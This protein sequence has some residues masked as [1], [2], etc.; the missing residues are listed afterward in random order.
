MRWLYGLLT[1]GLCISIFS[2]T[3]GYWLVSHP[4]TTQTPSPIS[5]IVSTAPP[6]P[7]VAVVPHHNLVLDQRQALLKQLSTGSQ[8]ETIILVS[9]NHFAVGSDDVIVADKSW[10]IQQGTGSLEP[11]TDLAFLLE[12]EG[13]ASVDNLAFDTEHGIKNLLPEIAEFFPHSKL[14]PV[15]FKESVS[16]ETIQLLLTSLDS[17]CHTCG[18]IASVDMSHYQ[19]AQL[20]EIHD[21]KTLR[22]LT[23]LDEEEIWEAE[24]DSNASLAFLVGWAKKQQVNRFT[25]VD[26]T[27]SGLLA[28]NLDTETTTHIF[29][30]YDAGD[31][32]PAGNVLTFTFGGDGMFG[33][34]IGYQFQDNFSELFS[35]LGN[36]TFWGTDISWINLEGPISDQ[37]I[38][39]DR[40]RED[41]VFNFSKQTI[42][43]L[44]YLQLT[45]LGL[46]NNHT[47]NQGERGLATTRAELIEAGFDVHGHPSHVSAESVVRYTQDN[48]HVSLLAVNAL[49]STDG[50]EDL[51]QQ[52][53]QAGSVVVVLPHWGTEYQPQH[54]SLQ[55]RLATAWVAAGADLIIGM[56]PHVIQ[57]AQLINGVPVLYS[58]GNFVFDQTF[59]DETQQGLLV[60]GALTKTEITLVLVPIRSRQLKPEIL[61]GEEKQHILDQVCAGVTCTNGVI[62][63]SLRPAAL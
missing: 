48:I 14:L 31:A 22:A 11:N 30:Y 33:R 10:N 1:A 16:P 49:V 17:A 55:E 44:Q 60:T 19:P 58:L 50:L 46:G 20:A 24:V 3:S 15:I 36:R 39:Q 27:N 61:Q 2:L 6:T 63:A 56:H 42:Q 8:P 41:L 21:I 23:S 62:T 9:P 18:V 45:T 13:L 7:L 57:D 26:H 37:V 5:Q 51:I 29:G 38:L 40:Q 53:K 25:L 47:Y 12:Q 32:V 35:N 59:S 52:E 34:E 43:A 4:Q 54:S 28:N